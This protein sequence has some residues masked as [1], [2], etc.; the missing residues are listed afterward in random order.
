[1]SEFSSLGKMK[2][3]LIT[4]ANRGL[5][6]GM[7]KYLTKQNN[8][9]NIIATCRTVSEVDLI[10]HL[11]IGAIAPK[12]AY[13]NTSYIH[14]LQTFVYNNSALKTHDVSRSNTISLKE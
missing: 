13:L 1:M 2:N 9:Q 12:V 7:V 4:G 6:L 10:S 5:G 3:V 11:P 14:N 8:A